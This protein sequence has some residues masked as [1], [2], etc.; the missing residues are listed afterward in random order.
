MKRILF[1]ILYSSL[2]TNS[3]SQTA[4]QWLKKGNLKGQTG[5][6]NAAILCF[7]KAIDLKPQFSEAYYTRGYAKFIL[8]DYENA[9]IDFTKTIELDAK[10]IQA[11]IYRGRA[12][13]STYKTKESIEDFEKLC[14][15]L[16]FSIENS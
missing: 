13:W 3:Y 4:E 11:F 6:I 16:N 14:K 2:V 1:I 10:N 9:I 5:D 8:E 12:K 7:D 15:E